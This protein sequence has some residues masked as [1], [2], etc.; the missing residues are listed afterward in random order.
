MF[1]TIVIPYPNGTW[2]KISGKSFLITEFD[3]TFPNAFGIPLS[4]IGFGAWLP[5]P[6]ITIVP[7]PPD[8]PFQVPLQN[9]QCLPAGEFANT[10]E[11]ATNVIGP[12]NRP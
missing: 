4:S 7:D 2:N 6:T 5:P 1:V 12:N 3:P 11:F 9:A 8:P 10:L